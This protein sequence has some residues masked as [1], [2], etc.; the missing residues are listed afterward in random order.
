L[1][2]YSVHE[3]NDSKNEE[4]IKNDPVI[5]EYAKNFNSEKYQRG[6]IS[7]SGPYSFVEY[8]TGQ[9]VVL[10]RKKDWWGDKVATGTPG[11]DAIPGQL[12]YKVITDD[13]GAITAMK[14]GEVDVMGRIAPPE[15]RKLMQDSNFKKKNKLCT[16]P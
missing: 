2:K 1:K 8:Q 6:E 4:R 7:G 3:L 9:K 5:I 14:N 16:P 13:I 15:F 11:F 10:K 12:V